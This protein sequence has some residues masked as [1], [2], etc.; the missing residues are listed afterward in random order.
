LERGSGSGPAIGFLGRFVEEK[1]IDVLLDAAPA[2]LE[3]FPD[4]TFQLAGAAQGVAGGS[5]LPRLQGKIEALGAHVALPGRLSDEALP[6]FYASLD[7]FV[8][9]SINAY[10]AF[11][12]VQ[13]EAMAQGTPVIASDLPGVR[14]TVQLT[15]IGAL[16]R[17]GD[18][19]ALADAVI[20]VLHERRTRNEVR[21]R[22]LAVFSNDRFLD[23]YERLFAQH[24][25]R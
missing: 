15:G 16:A 1:G 14:R 4:A 7:A 22:A 10:E 19:R 24:A 25:A 18:A 21:Q 13:A 5:I 17:A 11:G 3:K 8:L 23:D 12:M 9:P 2:I 6:L 20:R